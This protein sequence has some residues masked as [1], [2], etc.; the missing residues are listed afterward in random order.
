MLSEV[1]TAL[2]SH[3]SADPT[4]MALLK[5]ESAIICGRLAPTVPLPCITLAAN[6]KPD[7][8]AS[9]L[10][11]HEVAVQISVYSGSP[12]TGDAIVDA[13]DARL[14]DGHREGSLDTANYRVVFCRRISSSAVST[15]ARHSSLHEVEKRETLWRI[16]LLRKD[17]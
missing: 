11:K 15:D 8:A 14:F 12:D 1:K 2:I 7:A 10:G 3:L 13:L 16:V 9:E 4:L 6:E 5:T 17:A